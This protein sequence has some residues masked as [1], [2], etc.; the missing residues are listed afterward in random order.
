MAFAGGDEFIQLGAWRLG[1]SSE[2]GRHFSVCHRSGYTAMIYRADGTLHPGPRIDFG[3]WDKSLGK[4][5]FASNV[6]VGDCFVQ[7]G[8]WRIG[9]VQEDD[10]HLSISHVTGF[11]SAI[12]RKDGTVHCNNNSRR[13][14]NT[15]IPCKSLCTPHGVRIAENGKY[16]Q[17]GNYWRMGDVDTVHFSISSC[18]TKTGTCEI[19]RSD[20]T[21]HPGPRCD[22]QCW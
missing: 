11:T 21:V 3:L 14:W 15:H 17:F 7:I 5:G 16:I 6:F 13:D 1:V 18:D 12:W 22:F 2:D 20:G 19:W 10:G 9:Q 8:E 4:K